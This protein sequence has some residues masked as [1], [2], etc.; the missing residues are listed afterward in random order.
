MS[1]LQIYTSV[2]VF[3]TFILLQF[4]INS[5]YSQTSTEPQSNIQSNYSKNKSNHEKTTIINEN[6]RYL[7]VYWILGYEE[8]LI[9]FIL[10]QRKETVHKRQNESTRNPLLYKKYYDI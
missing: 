10:I 2:Q 9:Y 1:V 7:F 4:I 6:F 8:N 3:T 5:P